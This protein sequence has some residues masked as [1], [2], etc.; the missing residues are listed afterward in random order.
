MLG[1]NKGEVRLV[2]HAADWEE[3]FIEEKE[4]LSEAIGM[5]V[6]DIEHMGSTSIKGIAAKPL[7]DILVGVQSMDD[8]AKFD[9]KEIE[10]SRLLSSWSCGNR[11]E[12][13]LR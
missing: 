9:Q 12:S 8:V 4:L 10:R 5:Q 7:L 2:P 11:R 13:S 3:N 1:L 6:V